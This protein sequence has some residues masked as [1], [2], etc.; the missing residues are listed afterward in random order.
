MTPALTRNLLPGMLFVF[1]ATL[2][3]YLVTMPQTITLEDAGLF[4]MICHNGGIGHPPG[5]PL[6]ILSCQAFVNLPGFDQSVLAGN[7]MSAVFA[8]AASAV[9]VIV[10]RQCQMSGLL[11]ISLAL[12]YG[13]SVTFWSQAII[14]E[15]Y[16]LA[17]LLFLVCLSLTL[18][19]QKSEQGK[20]LLWLALVYGLA[21]SNH[22]PLQGLATPALLVIL[23]PRIRSI[24]R[25][26][27]VPTNFLAI[28]ALLGLGLAPYLTLFQ[29]SP[30]FSIYGPV[31]TGTDF[32]NYI[33]RA[34]Y[35][36]QGELAG[37]SDKLSFQ[38]WLARQSL[39]EL[40]LP[41]GILAG[42]GFL[43]SFK[44]LPWH[45]S[46][47]L[48]LLYLGA[49]SILNLMLGFEFNDHRVAIFGPYP[50]IS[51]LALVVWLGIAV[52]WLI[53]LA[54]GE[55]PWLR[56]LL[57]VLLV[58]VVS[59]GNFPGFHYRDNDFVQ[60][61]G[62][63]VLERVPD[64]GVLFVEG[65]VGVG[66]IGY[67]HYVQNLR[68][69]IELRSWNNLVFNN[70]LISPYASLDQQA[71]VRSEFIHRSEKQV[72]STI[73]HGEKGLSTGLLFQHKVESGYQCDQSLHAYIG[74]LVAVDQLNVLGNGHEKELLF[75]LLVELSRLHIALLSENKAV[76]KDLEAELAAM[77]MLEKTFPGKMVVIESRLWNPG[78]VEQNIA[79]KEQ[80]ELLVESAVAQMPPRANLRIQ[81]LLEDY[82]GRV[83]L[84]EPV[85]LKLA[86]SHFERSIS[87]NP[88]A[89]NTSV[90][91]LYQTYRQ[92]NLEVRASDLV[93]RFD[94]IPCE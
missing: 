76:D 66:M 6:F 31:E 24:S 92:L 77:A 56:Q 36:D 89:V 94:A 81:A 70:R 73:G 14:V 17:V 34:A 26:L 39:L 52:Q 75:G 47:A 55:V 60:A 40:T 71:K 48:V 62:E 54:G 5:Y 67:L 63:R 57:P 90:C 10:F 8:S 93:N 9:L 43:L 91:P 59:L 38:R 27:L 50:V 1:L 15:V 22:W 33:T 32:V 78:N 41:L 61:Y 12:V 42:L 68:P 23:A 28:V 65:D 18:V 25:F 58:A 64:G 19:Y 49:T 86:A 2:C 84:V 74:K 30:E 79:Q 85:D 82:Q 69:D 44:R 37:I 51:Y 83:A 35:I 87:L 16:S 88:R 21:L 13:L 80:L 29:S 46:V 72:F 7:L 3:L 4:Q 20:Y 11:S 45:L 53:E